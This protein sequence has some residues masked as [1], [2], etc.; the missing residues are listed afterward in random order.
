MIEFQPLGYSVGSY[1]NVGACWLWQPQTEDASLHFDEG[2]RVQGSFAT[3]DSEDQF[4]QAAAAL[5]MTASEEVLKLRRLFA[6][7][8]AAVGHLEQKR[9]RLAPDIR[10]AWNLV[11]ALALAGRLDEARAIA[12]QDWPPSG[13]D[14]VR[15]LQRE[16]AQLASMQ[17]SELQAAV[18]ANISA[19]R[20]ALRLDPRDGGSQL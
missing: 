11:M 13:Y 17:D 9:G 12:R 16:L 7:P 15:N 10:V 14:W 4:A 6:T 3:F 20:A 18:R 2:H 8:A 1:L 5:A 19:A